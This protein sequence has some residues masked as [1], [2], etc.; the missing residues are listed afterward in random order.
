MIDSIEKPHETKNVFPV[1]GGELTLW[2]NGGPLPRSNPI[3][4]ARS[5][6]GKDKNLFYHAQTK[7][8]QISLSCGMLHTTRMRSSLTDGCSIPKR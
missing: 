4:S 8:F 2:M 5:I 7:P 1:K 3:Y 6:Q